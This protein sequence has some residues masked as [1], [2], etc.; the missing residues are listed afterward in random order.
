MDCSRRAFR[1]LFCIKI[2]QLSL[3]NTKN[4]HFFAKMFLYMETFLYLCSDFES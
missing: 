3:K 1:T 4:M 2:N